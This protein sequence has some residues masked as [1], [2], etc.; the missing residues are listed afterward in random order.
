MTI[1][2]DYVLDDTMIFLITRYPLFF[3]ERRMPNEAEIMVIPEKDRLPLTEVL[4]FMYG[5]GK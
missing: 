1:K 5:K 4:N 3:I 2:G